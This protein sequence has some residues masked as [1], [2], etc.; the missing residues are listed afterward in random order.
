MSVRFALPEAMHSPPAAA[1]NKSRCSR[2]IPLAARP[3][4]LRCARGSAARRMTIGGA[5]KAERPQLGGGLGGGWSKVVPS[6]SQG[7]V[8]VVGVGPGLGAAVA[9]RFARER[10]IVAILARDLGF[11][12]SLAWSFAR[13]CFP[14]CLEFSVSS[15][16]VP[17]PAIPLARFLAPSDV[18]GVSG[19]LAEVCFVASC[20]LRGRPLQDNCTS[21][22]ITNVMLGVGTWVGLRPSCLNS[23][24]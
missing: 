14:R 12:P 24:D 7:V 11:N 3:A 15:Q 23:L 21:P 20:K 8:A 4:V 22:R 9:R 18:V 17:P 6:A 13:W 10:Y 1:S 5:A 2:P 16:D 19:A